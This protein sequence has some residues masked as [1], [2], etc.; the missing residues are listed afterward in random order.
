MEKI[1]VMTSQTGGMAFETR[2][3]DR[4]Y[5]G[6]AWRLEARGFIFERDFSRITMRQPDIKCIRT[7]KN[8][9]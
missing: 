1:P 2:E 7:I 8:Q 4:V 5:A 6:S 3:V 9:N